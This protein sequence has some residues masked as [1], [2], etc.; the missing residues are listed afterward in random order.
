MFVFQLG[1]VFDE[2]VDS[3]MQ[4]MGYC[5]GKR[6][7]YTPPTLFCVGKRVCII[8]RDTA[9]YSYGEQ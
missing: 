2:T 4:N 8:P 6:L 3:V 5:C 9:Y 1:K 7:F